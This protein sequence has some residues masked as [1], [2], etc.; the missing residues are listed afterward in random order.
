MRPTCLVL[1]AVLVVGCGAESTPTI[2]P[3]P[4]RD[5]V[6]TVVA[7]HWMTLT[8]EAIS[9]PTATPTDTAT[10]T[11]TATPTDTAT[12]TPPPAA[13][14]E[15]QVLDASS[16]Q[17][18]VGAQVALGDRQTTTNSE[19]RFL[20][21]DLAPGQYTV[22]VTSA[23]HDP[24]LSGIVDVRA[25]EQAVVDAALPA[26]GTGEYPRDPMAS[27]QIE[28]DGAPSAQE[29]ERLA[30]LQGL[31]GEVVSVREVTLEGEYLV[32]YRKGDAIRAA[33]ATLHHPA[34]ELVDEGGQAWYIVR[35]C[36]NLAMVRPALPPLPAQCVATPHPV[37]TVGDH[38]LSAYACPSETCAVAAE[39]VADWHGVALACAPGCDWLQVQC[40]GITDGCWVRRDWLQIWGELAELPI[41]P[42]AVSGS[43]AFL[44]DRDTPGSGEIYLLDPT[45]GSPVR[46]TS[47]L[48]LPSVVSGSGDWAI[49]LRWSPDRRLFFFNTGNNGR[50]FTVNA[51]GTGARLVAEQIVG[52]DLSPDGER[53]VAA[54]WGYSPELDNIVVMTTEATERTVISNDA[55]RAALG[56]IPDTPLL[57]P[58]WSPDGKRLAF[59]SHTPDSIWMVNVDSSR[60]MELAGG[61]DGISG[62][63]MDWSPDGRY[64]LFPQVTPNGLVGIVDVSSGEIRYLLDSALHASWSPDGSQVVFHTLS[65]KRDAQISVINADGSGLTQLTFE[66]KNCCPVWLP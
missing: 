33:M 60:P 42:L 46:L 25:G 26:A 30:R 48:Q 8:P 32:N 57:G 28:P 61:L 38:P 59:Y 4:T 31:Q 65:A 35:V 66:G 49:S 44:S 63:H 55:V 19:G 37:V 45:G 6:A 64:I 52:M 12:P 1:L 9:M 36:G 10:P 50:F 40:P 27:N 29:A 54:I 39:L 15:G 13:Q 58:T 20:L 24:V 14:L 3:H 41:V 53:V 21:A 34:W 43:I 23:D 47:D 5:V 18:L 11:A 2:A 56:L 51:D 16:G 17:P 22:L 7:S 62:A